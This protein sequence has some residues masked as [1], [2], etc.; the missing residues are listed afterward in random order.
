MAPQLQTMKPH[1]EWKPFLITPPVPDHPSTHI[2][3]GWAAAELLIDVLGGKVRYSADSLTLPGVTRKYKGF[4]GA[5]DEMEC[6]GFMRAFTLC[7]R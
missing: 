7:M 2:V 5:A 1:P 6:R 4:A 3:L